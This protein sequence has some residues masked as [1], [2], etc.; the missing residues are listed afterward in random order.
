MDAIMYK[1]VV[2]ICVLNLILFH[3]LGKIS[4]AKL[5]EILFP[6]D[7]G[8]GRLEWDLIW[9][10]KIDVEAYVKELKIA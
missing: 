2:G 3:R 9:V 7:I 6:L 1:K 10:I 4:T 5:S 8:P